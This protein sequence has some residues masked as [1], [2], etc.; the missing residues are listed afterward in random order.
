MRLSWHGSGIA[1]LAPSRRETIQI[2][3]AT[4]FVLRRAGA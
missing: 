3:H 4:R 2:N 1:L